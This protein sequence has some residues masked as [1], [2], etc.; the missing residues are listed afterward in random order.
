VSTVVRYFAAAEEAAG[1]AEERIDGVAT[2]GE[3]RTLLAERYGALM[4]RVL[5]SGSLLVDGVATTD[6]RASTGARVDV[7]PPFAGG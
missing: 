1:C 4:R 2:V 3:L 7:L 6:V 5:D